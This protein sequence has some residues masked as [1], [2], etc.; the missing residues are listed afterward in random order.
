MLFAILDTFGVPGRGLIVLVAL[1]KEAHQ[2]FIKIGAAVEI[3][4]PDGAKTAATIS[5]CNYFGRHKN[6]FN[7]GIL[8][9]N[10]GGDLPPGC[11]LSIMAAGTAL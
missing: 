5:G 8:L 9:K 2:E 10:V 11:S 1:E 4:Y 6:P 7:I 3:V